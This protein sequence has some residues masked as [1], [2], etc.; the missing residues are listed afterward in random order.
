VIIHKACPSC[1]RDTE[2]LRCNWCGREDRAQYYS[3]GSVSEIGNRGW[4]L[5]YGMKDTHFCSKRCE[6]EAGQ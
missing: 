3:R 6:Q 4:V 2:Y 1:G 5:S